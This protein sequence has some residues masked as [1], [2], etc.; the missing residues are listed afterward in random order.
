MHCRGVRIEPAEVCTVCSSLEFFSLS[1]PELQMEGVVCHLLLILVVRQRFL[2]VSHF[3][4]SF[5]AQILGF[6]SCVYWSPLL[7]C[8]LELGVLIKGL[9]RLPESLY[10][11][12]SDKWQFLSFLLLLRLP[13]GVGCGGWNDS[14]HPGLW[15]LGPLAR[16]AEHRVRR[17]LGPYWL[18]GV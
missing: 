14:I 11:R 2:V 12:E 4:Y 10:K 9:W 13:P 8:N 6:F 1:L 16:V 15:V 18:L 17:N 7:P 5:I 3:F